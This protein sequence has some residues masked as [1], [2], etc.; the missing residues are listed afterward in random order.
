MLGPS[1]VQTPP[2]VGVQVRT[3]PAYTVSG[4]RG[5]IART[6]SLSSSRL[7]SRRRR[8]RPPFVV[9]KT[10]ASADAAYFDP[11]RLR[12]DRQRRDAGAVH[13]VRRS[14]FS[15]AGT[16]DADS[17]ERGQADDRESRE[18]APVHFGPDQAL[19]HERPAF[20]DL[21]TPVGPPA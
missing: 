5:S 6:F 15:R 19:C 20:V 10:P 14:P 13:A 8:V 21:N 11:R 7:L 12:V 9:L 1:L 17:E 18:Q 4:F 2:V 16:G 3:S